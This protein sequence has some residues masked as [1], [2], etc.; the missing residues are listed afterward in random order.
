VSDPKKKDMKE[1]I[2]DNIVK[3]LVL[4][5]LALLGLRPFCPTLPQVSSCLCCF[6]LG[7]P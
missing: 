4:A 6:P 3:V 5:G 2:F 7:L 1:D